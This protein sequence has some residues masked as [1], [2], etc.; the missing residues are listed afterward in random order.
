MGQIRER[1]FVQNFSSGLSDHFV[2]SFLVKDVFSLSLNIY[3]CVSQ[4]LDI[5]ATSM[6]RPVCPFLGFFSHYDQLV[7]STIF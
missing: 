6:L 2:S 1:P 3:H 4:Y 5:F 7:D